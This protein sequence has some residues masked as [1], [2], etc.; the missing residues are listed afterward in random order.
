M[1]EMVIFNIWRLG[2]IPGQSQA[3]DFTGGKQASD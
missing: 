3:E 1:S 2:E